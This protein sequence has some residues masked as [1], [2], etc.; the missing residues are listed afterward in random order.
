MVSLV[1]VLLL[2]LMVVVVMY[3]VVVVLVMRMM[4]MVLGVARGLL[5]R[6]PGADPDRLDLAA[7][8]AAVVLV[9]A[10]ALVRGQRVAGGILGGEG[11]VV[12][13]GD[14]VRERSRMVVR[15]RR[16]GRLGGQDGCGRWPAEIHHSFASYPRIFLLL[17]SV[18]SVGVAHTLLTH[19]HIHTISLTRATQRI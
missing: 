8:A 4:M 14:A 17:S 13:G 10:S 6:L 7:A 2:L 15:R 11:R 3:L 9:V 5:E 19:T 18:S 1:M 16:V 12:G